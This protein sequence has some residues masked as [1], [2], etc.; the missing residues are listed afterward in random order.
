MSEPSRG[1]TVYNVIVNT[2][3]TSLDRSTL[4]LLVPISV[5]CV[6]S[7]PRRNNV[8]TYLSLGW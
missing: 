2:Y 4:G 5:E 3:A 8:M 1:V 7:I 6:L